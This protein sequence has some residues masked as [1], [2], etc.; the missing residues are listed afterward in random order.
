M[1]ESA[2]VT[3]DQVDSF[4]NLLSEM[5]V[6]CRKLI[7]ANKKLK[8][9]NSRLKKENDRLD[10]IVA[11]RQ[12]SPVLNQKERIVL[13]KQLMTLIKRIDQHLEESE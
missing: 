13:K 10:H 12:A 3:K 11:Q 5:S 1:Q 9:E 2:K 7:D 4:R 6:E 8:E